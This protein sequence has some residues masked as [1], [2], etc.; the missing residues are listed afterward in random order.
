MHMLCKETTFVKKNPCLVA[1]TV[2]FDT[3]GLHLLTFCV[4]E[5]YPSKDIQLDLSRFISH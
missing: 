1:R 4:L 2:S 5:P 3:A